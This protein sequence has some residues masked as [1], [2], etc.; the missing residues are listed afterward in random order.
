MPTAIFY[1][2]SYLLILFLFSITIWTHSYSLTSI[3]SVS[4]KLGSSD[5]IVRT[6]L[7]RLNN[8][9]YPH[10]NSI[11]INHCEII[12]D[13]PKITGNK[14][15]EKG[16]VYPS[17]QGSAVSLS[18][19][20]KTA[21]VGGPLDD[22]GRGAL[23]VFRHVNGVWQQDG[24]K[25]VVTDAEGDAEQG[26]SVFISADGKTA[27]VGGP[28]DN[29]KKGAVWIFRDVNGLWQQ[30]GNKLVG[31]DAQGDAEQGTSVSLSA[32][33]KTAIVGG[34]NDDS[35]IGAVWVFRNVNGVWRQAGNKLV[36]T[37]SK[38][39]EARQ[40]RSVSLS[41]DGKTVI[42]GGPKDNYK[43]GAVWIFR[44]LNGLWQQEGNK[45]VGTGSKG[46][47]SRQGHSVSLSADGKTAL[48]GGPTDNYDKGAVWI[49]RNK[50]GLWQQEGNKLVG[51]E[52]EEIARQ[53]I[54]V[55]LSADGKTAFVGGNGNDDYKGSVWTF[56]YV[57]GKWQQVG[58]KLV[59]KGSASSSNQ[60]SA[61]SLSADSKTAIVGGS[62][63]DGGTGG[64]WIY[65][66]VNGVWQQVGSKLVGSNASL[67]WGRDQLGR[68][69]S[70]SADGKMA[71]V[72]GPGYDEK[73]V[74]NE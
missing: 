55:V 47:E 71:I 48:V 58:R 30:E 53:G 6:N 10:E 70:L 28:K 65:Q 67:F 73:K 8:V 74:R 3:S 26:T 21:I 17:G 2:S 61:I 27:I 45:L 18:A 34:P 19:D 24:N 20:G 5:K 46:E 7:S 44:D 38:G 39:E 13:T 43:K 32:D 40:G 49:Y 16:M 11:D 59:G 33:G 72:G 35:G 68:S 57:R 62:Y 14:L 4:L 37:G 66:I 22:G 64:V 15:V 29:D 52:S 23:W 36:G 51:A 12:V 56:S 63:F 42:V 1:K 31:S 9:I 41:A 54:Y 50:N 60:G 69:V 25:L